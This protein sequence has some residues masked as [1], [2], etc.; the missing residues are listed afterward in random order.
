MNHVKALIIKFVMIAV[1]L[2]IILTGFFKVS[3][4][5]TLWIS[6]VLTLVAYAMGDLMIFRKAGD[7]RD[8][9]KRNMIATISDIVV[10]FL[11]IWLVGDALIGNNPDIVTA[12]IISAIVIGAGEWF[13]HKY[14]DRNV[15]PE[16]HDHTTTAAR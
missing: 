4:V 12:S 13:F 16:K 9:N 2:L 11:V 8:Q 6:L 10:A 14:L 7:A 5:D 3:F 1:V 15:F